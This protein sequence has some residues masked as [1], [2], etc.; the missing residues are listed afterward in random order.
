[1][2]KLKTNFNY[3][4]IYVA[5]SS[6]QR[7]LLMKRRDNMAISKGEL[8]KEQTKL[9][10]VLE[11]IDK[12]L[13]DASTDLFLKEEELINFRKLNYNDK[14]SFDRAEFSQV[15][16]SDEME[17]RRILAK[18][19][20]YKSLVNIKDKP[21]FASFLYKDEEGNILDIYMALTYLRNDNYDNILYDWRSPICSLFYDY[22]IGPCRYKVDDTINKGELLKKRQYIIENR[23]LIN[24]F[25]NSLNIND[26]LLQKTI[27]TT[28]NEK[29]KNIVNTIQKEQNEIIR[30]LDDHNLIV[31]GIAGS[32]KT[33]VA[34]HRIAF[35]LYRIKNL[36]SNNVLIFSP[37]SIFSEYISNVLPELGEDNTL[38]STF[39]DYLSYFLT[40]Y[41]NIES[42]S[43]FIS[44]YYK[45]NEGDKDIICYKQSKDI[46][47]DLDN[48]INHLIT[49]VKVIND[50]ELDKFIT[51]D[52]DFINILLKDKFSRFPLF[53]RLEEIAK[54]LSLKYYGSPG[55]KKGQVRK[56]LKDNLNIPLN[57]KTLYKDFFQSDFV[58]YKLTIKSVKVINY[59]D[60][61]LVSYLKGR[62]FGFPYNNYIKE[63][64][65]DEAQDYNYLQYIII[66]EMF[67]K[68]DF[69]ILGDVNQNINP[70]YK[71][72]SLEELKEIFPDSNYLELRKTYRSA[73]EI[74]EYTNKILNLDYVNAIKKSNHKDVLIRKPKDIKQSLLHDIDTLTK[75]YKSL[76]IITKED[77]KGEE[78]HNLL[79]DDLNI[80][81]LNEDS[82]KFTK[83]LVVVPSYIAK[84]LEFDSVIIIDQDHSFKIDKYLYYV[85]C[86]RAREELII[87]E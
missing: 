13:D 85:A 22:E 18:R 38:E 16:T 54:Y 21:Y 78:I 33:S 60:A 23:N 81:L 17:A 19:K 71:Y 28:D 15:M 62:L 24:V 7:T 73:K 59:D 57:L 35:L 65:I 14:S 77:E 36:K 66:K 70:Y 46:I 83:D 43:N 4:L 34:L 30:N 11:K 72:E 64:V 76:A 26:E 56:L 82:K 27:A 68:A 74:I 84:G 61:L 29:M 12:T 52:S 31:Q 48:Y 55:K 75:I 58:K 53:E 20:C 5:F 9:I 10:K 6:F 45:G 40:E 49:N 79:K 8:E 69:T 2:L 25:D 63:V 37:N 47:K 41:K 51:V 39:S 32:G 42:F 3:I 1:M 50:I 44:R 80:S 87:Y 86:T 67:K